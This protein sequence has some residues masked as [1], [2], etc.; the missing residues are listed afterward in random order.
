MGRD[1]RPS[2]ETRLPAKFRDADFVDVELPGKLYCS[3][4]QPTK[5][6]VFMIACDAVQRSP[7]CWEWCH[8]ACVG[9]TQEVNCTL[10]LAAVALLP[11]C[12]AAALR[13]ETRTGREKRALCYWRRPAC[14]AVLPKAF[15]LVL[16]CEGQGCHP[17]SMHPACLENL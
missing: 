15:S 6:G 10:L 4:R 16:A 14:D 5:K 11:Q 8:G 1:G 12:S 17:F 2:R 7:Q 13:C 3:C 9:I